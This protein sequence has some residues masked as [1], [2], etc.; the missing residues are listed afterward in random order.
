L[1][2]LA[3][4]PEGQM[5]RYQEG[6]VGTILDRWQAHLLG[7]LKLAEENSSNVLVVKYEDLDRNPA[8]VTRRVLSFLG[9]CHPDV[10]LRPDRIGQT[11]HIPNVREIPFEQREKIRE[12]ISGRIGSTCVIKDLYPEVCKRA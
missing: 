9:L 4:P 1:D 6:Q 5:L 10:I 2:F 3:T 7:W 12:Y 8:D 11:V